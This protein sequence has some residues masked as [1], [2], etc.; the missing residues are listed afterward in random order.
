MKRM[1]VSQK[2]T[3]IEAESRENEDVEMDVWH[4]VTDR[5]RNKVIRDKVEVTSVANKMRGVRLR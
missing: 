3:C 4:T 1:L 5:I 2:L